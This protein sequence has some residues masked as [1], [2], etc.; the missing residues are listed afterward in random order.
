LKVDQPITTSPVEQTAAI[1]PDRAEKLPPTMRPPESDLYDVMST[2]RAM[3]R[4][5][6]EPVPRELIERLIQAASWA[7][8]GG[9]SQTTRYIVVDDRTQIAR[10]APLWRRVQGFYVTAQADAFPPTMSP[11]QWQRTLGA[12]Q[13]LADHFEDVPAL[14]VVCCDMSSIMHNWL[15]NAAT[16]A[17][18]FGK[19]GIRRGVTGGANFGKF[20]RLSTAASVYPAVQNLLLAARQSGLGASLTTWHAMYERELK[21]ILGIPRNVRT[22]A[23]VP[24]GYPIGRFGPV[25]RAPVDHFLHWNRW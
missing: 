2:M 14:I 15:A 9:N 24:I 23:V 19:L 21:D 16:V 12:S 6:P 13:Y 17:R 8:S 25:S 20:A 10:I 5:R 3:R 22:F 18:A 1:P 7:P 11:K 4:L